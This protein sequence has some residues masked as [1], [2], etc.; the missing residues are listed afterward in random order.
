MSLKLQTARTLKWNAIDRVATQILYAVV[1]V[2]LANILSPEEFGLV[3]VLLIFQAFATILVDSG[4][5]AALLREKDPTQEDYSTVFWFNLFVSLA[6]YAILFIGAPLIARIFQGQEVLIPMSK[7]MFLTFVI[8]G[9]SIVQVNRLMKKMDVRMIAVS[10]SLGLI[11]SGAVAIW[12]AL[13]GAGAWAL[14]WQSIILASVKTITLWATGGWSP[15]L[16]FSKQTIRKI[17]AV[18]L[19]VFSSSLLNTISLNIYN[20]VIGAF[21]T[22]ASLGVYTQADKWA[23]MGSASLSQILT[24]SFVPLLSR[25][26]DSRE[27]FLRYVD[28]AGRFT[29]FILLPAMTLLAVMSAP[30]FHLLF[31]NKWDAAIPLFSIL[32][33][34]GIFVVLISLYSNYLLA[35]GKARNLFASEAVKDGL[36]FIAI[37]ATIFLRDITWLIIGQLAASVATWLLLLPLTARSISTS[38]GRLLSHLLPFSIASLA[39]AGGAWGVMALAP[40]FI[41]DLSSINPFTARIVSNGLILL[42]QG[43]IGCGIYLILLRLGNISELSEAAVYIFGRFRKK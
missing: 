25:V 26:Q 7:V 12:L 30:L 4:F 23:K 37:L 24:S 6:I 41:P 21:Y 16:C 20:F 3:G 11:V 22:I 36:I 31:G 15:S 9:V 8:N 13:K 5:G 14:V 42:L 38:P 19:S 43:A 40:Y 17:R 10:N 34:R 29:S 32:A 18:G 35:L 27:T 1:G 28:K 2:V 39:M 33:I